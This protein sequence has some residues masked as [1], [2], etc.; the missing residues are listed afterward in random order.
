MAFEYYCDITKV[1]TQIYEEKKKVVQI[2]TTQSCAL[3]Y[4]FS[5]KYVVA[6]K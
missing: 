4:L 2:N 1:I 5:I 6:L 3:L